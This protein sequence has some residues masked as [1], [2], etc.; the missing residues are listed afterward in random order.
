MVVS[1]AMAVVVS[2]LLGAEGRGVLA[3]FQLWPGVLG[4]LATLGLPA[5]AAFHLRQHPRLGAIVYTNG[6]VLVVLSALMTALAGSIVLGQLL[7]SLGPEQLRNARL[8]FVVGLPLTAI[9][10]YLGG[11]GQTTPDMAIFN[12]AKVMPVL[13]QV[14]VVAVIL[15]LHAVSAEAIAFGFL[16]AQA[17]VAL[18]LLIS[19]ARQFG[20]AWRA[21]RRV[22]AALLA[23]GGG[24]WASEILGTI[25]LNADKLAISAWLP[26]RDLGIYSV[27]FAISRA[28]SHVPNSI[29]AIIFP[30]NVGRTPAEVVDSTARAFRLS[31]W[32]VLIISVPLALACYPLFGIVFG[33]DFAIGG[34][35]LPL[36]VVECLVGTSSWVLAQA[37]N[38]LARPGLVVVRQFSGL[39]AFALLASVLM[40]RY[41]IL[42]AALSA[43]GAAVVR[44]LSTLASFRGGL[45]MPV[46]FV[47]WR[48]AD[49]QDLLSMARRLR[50]QR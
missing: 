9:F 18:W 34:A 33:H 21:P 3:A 10:I 40:P 32:P 48:H 25:T 22:G 5:A 12:A 11:C 8:Y 50:R 30:R 35:I 46:P 23:Y 38:S 37:F 39:V 1:L 26:L 19:A 47:G 44:L 41:G 43:L 4:G 16:L 17:C 27:A 42:G 7:P 2:R 49:W 6:L 13:V 29:A 15:G 31:F 20:H 24:I 28:V 45:K 36:L 14:P